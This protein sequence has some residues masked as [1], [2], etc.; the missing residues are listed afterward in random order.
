[1]RLESQSSRFD[2]A[3]RRARALEGAVRSRPERAPEA[4]G[5][6]RRAA[7][8][9]AEPVHVASPAQPAAPHDAESGGSAEARRRRR[10]RRGRRGGTSRA[11]GEAVQG[12]SDQVP[13]SAAPSG[14]AGSEPGADAGRDSTQRP[15]D[16]NPPE[17]P[18]HDDR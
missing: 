4:D 13:G 18:E 8:E 11:P 9:Q 3:E 7:R 15:E 16:L 2:F 6:Q 17:P 10:R 1:M 5:G 12:G 14:G